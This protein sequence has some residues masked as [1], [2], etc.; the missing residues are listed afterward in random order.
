MDSEAAEYR[1]QSQ[2]A[3]V[4]RQNTFLTGVSLS[5]ESFFFNFVSSATRIRCMSAVTVRK[6]LRLD[7]PQSPDVYVA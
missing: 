5:A 1:F 3:C 6:L 4:E 2:R 7:S